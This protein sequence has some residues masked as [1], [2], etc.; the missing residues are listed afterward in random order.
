MLISRAESRFL[1]RNLSRCNFAYKSNMDLCA[2][3]PATDCPNIYNSQP[4]CLVIS[5]AGVFT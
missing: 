1:E 2:E 4:L 3:K 5:L